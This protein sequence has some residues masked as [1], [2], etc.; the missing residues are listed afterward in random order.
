MKGVLEVSLSGMRYKN[1][2]VQIFSK[3]N[4]KEFG[5]KNIIMGEGIVEF[6]N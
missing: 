6:N 2:D 1:E 5:D 3:S 4:G